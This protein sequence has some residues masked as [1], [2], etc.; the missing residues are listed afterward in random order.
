MWWE[1]TLHLELLHIAI[2]KLYVQTVL[3]L[4][5]KS[6]LF[7]ILRPQVTISLKAN[8]KQLVIFQYLLV[9]KMYHYLTN[10]ANLRHQ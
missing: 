4:L 2:Y 7:F 9:H 8:L 1:L 5:K 10:S 3:V 6:L